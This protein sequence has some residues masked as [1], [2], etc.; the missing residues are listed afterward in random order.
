MSI[1]LI[2]PITLEI[3]LRV[4][5]KAKDDFNG[6]ADK[7]MMENGKMEKSKEVVCG[8]DLMVFRMLVNG[9]QM[10]LKDLVF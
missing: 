7:Y 9:I 2:N 5:D 8:K 6:V 10:P 3:L 1:I 4:E